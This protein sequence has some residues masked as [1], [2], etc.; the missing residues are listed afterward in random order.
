MMFR[1]PCSKNGW[2]TKEARTVFSTLPPHTLF[3]WLTDW[4]PVFLFFILHSLALPPYPHVSLRL[5]HA[6]LSYSG[7]ITTTTS[8][9]TWPDPTSS[10]ICQQSKQ[11]KLTFSPAVCD[12]TDLGFVADEKVYEVRETITMMMVH[13]YMLLDQPGTNWTPPH[14]LSSGRLP[15]PERTLVPSVVSRGVCT[16]YYN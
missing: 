1:A 3:D 5:L 4:P 14:Q 7:T 2:A 8:D 9:L 12:S 16:V 15:R 6:F 13:T 11:K 10:T